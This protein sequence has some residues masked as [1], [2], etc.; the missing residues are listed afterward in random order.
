MQ[1][2]DYDDNTFPIVMF[3]F[4]GVIIVAVVSVLV[5]THKT[6]PNAPAHAVATGPKSSVVTLPNG[7]SEFCNGTTMIYKTTQALTAEPNSAEC[8]P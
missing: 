5:L 3:L 6:S 2:D 7:V 8:Q 1:Y 4:I